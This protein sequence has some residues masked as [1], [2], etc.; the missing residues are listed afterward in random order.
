MKSLASMM[1]VACSIATTLLLSPGAF[2]GGL[3]FQWFHH[4]YS[5]TAVQ[6]APATVSLVPVSA[7]SNVRQVQMT[8][9]SLTPVSAVQ[10]QS[11]Q[12]V[13]QTATIQLV[14]QT[15][16]MQAGVQSAAP[17][18]SAGTGDPTEY[19]Y[20][21]LSSGLKGFLNFKNFEDLLRKKAGEFLANRGGRTDQ[22]IENLLLDFARSSLS[23][24]GFGFLIDAAVE[25]IL[26]R[27][28]GKVLKDNR[29]ASDS[30]PPAPSPQPTPN[31]PTGGGG[32]F[33]IRGT[34]TLIPV[35]GGAPNNGPGP[36]A[37]PQTGPVAPPP[38]GMPSDLTPD[39]GSAAPPP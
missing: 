39:G 3:G 5:T 1:H 24:S 15:Q 19:D 34:I 20:Q 37:P 7:V 14:P 22:E 31:G 9:V 18:V 13:P 28:I 10:I 33:E 8:G 35:S 26:K 16:S 2:A 29:P 4:G 30:K 12:F 11:V 36:V 17:S 32:T 6:A 38:P 25:P 21:V 27:L 23:S